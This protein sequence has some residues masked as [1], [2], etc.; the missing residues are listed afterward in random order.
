MA[1]LLNTQVVG[2]FSKLLS[3]VKKQ[4]NIT[5][6]MSYVDKRLFDGKGYLSSGWEY[7]K[8]T[9]PNYFYTNGKTRFSRQKFNKQNCLKLWPDSDASKTEHQL[10]YEHNLFRIYD[11]GNMVMRNRV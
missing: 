1:T 8:D 9:Y 11:C 5:E 7:V 6:I 4:E 10:C 3:H 2:G